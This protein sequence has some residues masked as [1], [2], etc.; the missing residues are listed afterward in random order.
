MLIEKNKLQESLFILFL[1]AKNSR[2][3]W[4]ENTL[5]VYI[6]VFSF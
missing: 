2:A 6:Y 4:F 3:I 5:S 1:K